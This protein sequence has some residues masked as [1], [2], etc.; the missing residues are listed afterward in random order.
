MLP[1]QCDYVRAV[2]QTIP[3]R[4]REV[5]WIVIHAMQSAEKPRVARACANWFGGLAGPAPRASAHFC[6]DKDEIVQ[7]VQL[8]DIAWAAPGLN[9]NGIHVELAGYSEQSEADWA[10]PYSRAMLERAARLCAWLCY[11]HMI[12]AQF[13]TALGILTHIR[14]IT[15]HAEGTLAFHTPGGHWDPGPGFPRDAFV[16]RVREILI[17]SGCDG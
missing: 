7:C 12:P 4:P 15:T 8:G 9:Q 3:S 16:A 2:N 5:D 11:D 10:D 6:V 14:G 13:V 1:V 17:T